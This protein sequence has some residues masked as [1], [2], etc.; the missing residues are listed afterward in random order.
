MK[1]F[2]VASVPGTSSGAITLPAAALERRTAA[3]RRDAAASALKSALRLLDAEL[4]PS[5]VPARRPKHIE[6]DAAAFVASEAPRFDGSVDDVGAW[7][8]S[9]VGSFYVRVGVEAQALRARARERELRRR[10]RQ[11]PPVQAVK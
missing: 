2:L 4:F 10:G 11:A 7:A 8:K 3:E 1:K 6:L 9:A 5:T